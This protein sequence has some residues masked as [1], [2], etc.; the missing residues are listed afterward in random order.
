[1]LGILLAAGFSRRF[2]DTDKLLHPLADSNPMALASAQHL[3]QAIPDS[4]AVVRFGNQLLAEALLQAGLQ[5][6]YCDE[7]AQDMAESLSTAIRYSAS[8]VSTNQASANDGFVIALADMPYISTSTI[9]AV[10]AQLKAGSD[11]VMPTFQ[12]QRGH[13]VGFSPKY[14]DEL[15][16]VKGDEGARSVI[17]RHADKVILLETQDAGILADIDTLSDIKR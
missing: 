10:A 14:R 11:I 7:K 1:M 3:I 9:L 2:G 12:G 8:L 5:V 6:V 4:I 17:R 13:P 16:A 15:L